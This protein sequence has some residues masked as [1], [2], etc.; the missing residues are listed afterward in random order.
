MLAFTKALH[1][2]G[3][4]LGSV[5]GFSGFKK[6]DLQA[7]HQ[8]CFYFQHIVAFIVVFP[9]RFSGKLFGEHILVQP[10][11]IEDLLSAYP[12]YPWESKQDV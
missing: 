8:V 7:W 4:V 11:H 1:I 5:I 12:Y 3:F 9:A 2:P 6:D 10:F